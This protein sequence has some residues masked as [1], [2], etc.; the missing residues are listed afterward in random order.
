MPVLPRGDASLVA[1]DA[2][3]PLVALLRL[4][5]ER[6]DGAR[7]QP[8]ERDRLAGLLA[9]AV[10]AVLETGERRLDLGDQLAL[11]VARAQL[12]RPVGL[13]G[14]TVGKIRMILVLGLE[15]GQRLLGLFEDLLLPREQLLAEI[16]RWRSFMKGSLSEGR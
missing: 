14:R 8:L 9:I 1:V 4:D 16:L 12:N 10:A 7:L 6:G 2:L 13:R 3:A 11:A 5:R 15:M